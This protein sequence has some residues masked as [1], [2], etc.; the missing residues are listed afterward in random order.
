ME[1]VENFL[2]T[3]ISYQEMYEEIVYFIN[4]FDIRCG[5]LECNDYIVKKVDQNNFFIFVED[6]YPDGKKEINNVISIPKDL[7]VQRIQQHAKRI[8]LKVIYPK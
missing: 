8:G 7:L 6:V 5:E 3:E 4:L 2:N 1:I